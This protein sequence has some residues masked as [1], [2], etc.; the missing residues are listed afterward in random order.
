MNYPHYQPDSD[1]RPLTDEE[2]EQLDDAL[3]ATGREEALNV[4]ALDGFL[5]ALL[6]SPVPL[7]ARPGADWL[8]AIWGGDEPAPFASGKQ[9]KRVVMWVLRHLQSIDNAW[10]HMPEAW[11]PIYSVAETD[12]GEWVDAQDWAAG[13]LRGVALDEAA[14]APRFESGPAAA[15][16]QSLAQLGAE[17]ADALPM[18]DI[19]RLSRALPEAVLQCRALWAGAATPHA[20]G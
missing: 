19:D 9:G 8:P 16:L 2:I 14:W 4:E 1:H 7:P 15:A 5:A 13:F 10:R 18:E 20:N 11:E 17:E 3:A 6:L 12:E